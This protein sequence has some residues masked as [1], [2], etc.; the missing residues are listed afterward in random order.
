VNK[1]SDPE[2]Q[3]E[4][5]REEAKKLDEMRL[6]RAS[7]KPDG[8][9]AYEQLKIFITERLTAYI[10]SEQE[11]LNDKDLRPLLLDKFGEMLIEERIVLNR[12]ERRK[13]IEDVLNEVLDPDSQTNGDRSS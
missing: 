13:L 5:E 6:K 4:F 12:S 8:R 7:P 10:D 9:N 11:E 1:S 3:P 2:I